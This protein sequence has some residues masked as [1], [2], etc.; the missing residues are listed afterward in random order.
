M[1]ATYLAAS[2]ASLAVAISIPQQTY[3]FVSIVAPK[4]ALKITD[5]ALTV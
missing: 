5:V 1:L 3:D 4:T 2:L